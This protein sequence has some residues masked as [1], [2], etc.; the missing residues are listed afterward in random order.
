MTT[1]QKVGFQVF[2]YMD[3]VAPELPEEN[4]I[5]F[6]EDHIPAGHPDTWTDKKW[7]SES[8][9]GKAQE[10]TRL[11]NYGVSVVILRSQAKGVY[12]TTRWEEV[13]KFKNGTWIIQ[14]RFV[15]REFK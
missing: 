3:E 5:H 13:L 12:V 1:D 10:F 14:S 4:Y 15:A 7:I 11:K 2:I 8:L 9:K 6:G